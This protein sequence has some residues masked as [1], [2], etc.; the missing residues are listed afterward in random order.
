M[1]TTCAEALNFLQ[2]G[3]SMTD[4][5]MSLFQLIHPLAESVFKKWMQE[6]LEYAQKIEYLPGG[7]HTIA[8]AGDVDQEVELR[9]S[10]VHIVSS[11]RGSETLQL[12]HL[13]VWND[14]IEVYEDVGAYAGQASTPFAAATLLTKG[15]DYYLDV[16]EGSGDEMLSDTGV[17]WRIGRWPEEPR[18][19]KV[20]YYGGYTATQLAGNYG[21]IKYA[22]LLTIE[23]AWRSADAR[24]NGSPKISE[25][26][27]KYSYT[28]SEKAILA[29]FG[30]GF[31]VPP[32]AQRAAFGSRNM[33]N[34][35][36]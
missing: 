28:R 24:A 23:K 8:T 16:D 10:T 32:E 14:D 12:T 27:G 34:I 31:T 30:E 15:T 4:A 18:C 35:F 21:N 17:L 25:D 6:D 3:T 33:G 7:T 26:I 5:K 22:A 11:D 36:G 29:A 1:I 2:V 13:P 19:V 9:G 20:V